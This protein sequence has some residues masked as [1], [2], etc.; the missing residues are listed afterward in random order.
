MEGGPEAAL[1]ALGKGDSPGLL[2]GGL[3]GIRGNGCA[4]LECSIPE[5]FTVFYGPR[6]INMPVL[7]DLF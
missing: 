2:R 4:S 5:R 7:T 6:A 1:R 3:R